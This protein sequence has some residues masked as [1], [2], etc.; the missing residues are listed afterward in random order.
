M[1]VS[2]TSDFQTVEWSREI[3]IL[4]K[5]EMITVSTYK[6]CSDNWP[7]VTTYTFVLV[8]SS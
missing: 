5:A 6:A 2:M 7:H 4:A 1:L 8:M 3:T